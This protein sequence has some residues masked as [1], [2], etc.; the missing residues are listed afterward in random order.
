MLCRTISAI[1][2]RASRPPLPVTPPT[3]HLEE[4]LTALARKVIPLPFEMGTFVVLQATEQVLARTGG[5][6]LPKAAAA[7]V[8]LTDDGEVLVIDA[9]KAADEAAA[10]RALVEL[11]GALLVRSAP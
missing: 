4:L 3:L 6:P 8:W 9:P 11:L 1:L 2:G 5:G 10:C 7:V